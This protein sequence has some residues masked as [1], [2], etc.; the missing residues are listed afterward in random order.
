[1]P[2]YDSEAIE[3]ARQV[4]LLTYLQT[5]EPQELVHVSGNVYCTKTHD[6]L[7][8]SNGKWCWFSRGIGGYS[9]LD[10]LIK[11]NGYS[12]LEAMETISGRA[13]IPPP[14][15]VPA[16]KEEKPK[17]LLLPQAAPDNRAMMAY[18]KGRGIDQ[19]ILDY[20]V[21]TGRIYESRNK[22]HSNVVFVG[23]DKDGKARFG[24]LRG[25]SEARFHG[26]LSGSDKHFSFALPACV[27]NPAVHLCECAIDVMSYA[28]LCKLDG[29]DWRR[30]NLLSLAG[31]Y[32]PKKQIEESKLPAALTRQ[33][34]ALALS[35]VVMLAAFAGFGSAK[36]RSKYNTA[37]QW[38]TV[39]VSADNG[40]NLSE[41]L[42]A[43]ANTAAN[44]ITTAGNTLGADNAEVQ[45]AQA[46][47][48][49]FSACL[50]AVQ[51]GGKSQALTSLSYYNGSSM[52]ALYQANETL[53][54]AIDQLYAKLQE[55]AA[56][57]MKMGAV[58]GQ[59][60]QFNS[61]GTIIGTLKYNEAVYNYRNE[62]GGFPANVLGGLAGVK[63]VEPFA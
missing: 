9:A 28:T 60:G 27:E 2:F 20:C 10:Y 18:L 31:I 15:F 51:S 50:D 58:Q 61:A 5:C 26:D 6:S 32:Q 52:H 23:F 48:D 40:Y 49:D 57:P 44:V 63:E 41:E 21:Q 7:R 12:F 54:K 39:G 46:A 11:V 59:Y 24:C 14:S 42:T 55:Q 62:V 13:A 33:A 37:R 43:R 3:R 19:E 35:I 47:L 56:D 25:I 22:G 29:I 16:P 36:V 45:T 4:D 34:V 17:H 38:F 8:I 1:M 30:H 53:G